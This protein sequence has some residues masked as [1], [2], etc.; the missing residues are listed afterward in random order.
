LALIG[1]TMRVESEHEQRRRKI[2][3]EIVRQYVAQGV[4]VGSQAVADKLLESLSS[5]TIRNVMAELEN[6][7]YL[8][9][10]H[11]SAG[12]VPTDKAYRFYVD[13]V[14]G[15]APLNSA[16]GR[17]IDRSLGPGLSVPEQL[18][19]A[20]S[21]VLSEV[22]HNVGVVVGPA[23]EEK[24]LEHIQF[25]KLSDQ[26]ILC[27]IVSRPDLIENRVIRLEEELS[28]EEL[29][30]TANYLNREFRGWSLGTI[31]LEIFKRMEADKALYDRLLKNVATLLMWGML[32]R[33]EPGAL[34]VEGMANI[35][36]Q[37]EF[38]DTGRIKELLETLD[39]KARLVK[40]LGA[41]L[42]SSDLGVRVLIG[43]EIPDRQMQ[44]CTVIAAPFHYRDRA[45][46]TL[47][48]VGPTRMEYERAIT[49]VNY[50]AQRC[51][52]LLS[53]N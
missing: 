33:E 11:P 31:R 4:P 37:P 2:L 9:Q 50:V 43:R 26:R 39:Q 14:V 34:F 19:A 47:G 20:T 15:S 52:K 16:T 3:G 8:G 41:C 32:A 23:L 17:Y 1:M 42:Q 6:E 24:L 18:L 40:I 45:V 7:G 48:V 36:G 10:P 30:Q 51:S 29:D 27:V 38:A 28:Q 21:H 12:R 46:G 53:S 5:A 13:Q 22:S 35:L 49:T 25:A 44:H